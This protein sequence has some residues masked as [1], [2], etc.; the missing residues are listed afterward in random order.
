MWEARETEPQNLG[1]NKSVARNLLSCLCGFSLW[2]S[3]D[4]QCEVRIEQIDDKSTESCRIPDWKLMYYSYCIQNHFIPKL[5]NCWE[6][7]MPWPSDVFNPDPVR[8]LFSKSTPQHLHHFH[9]QFRHIFA[10]HS[11]LLAHSSSPLFSHSSLLWTVG[12]LIVY[13]KSEWAADC[14]PALISVI[15]PGKHRAALMYC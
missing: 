8:P 4:S 12:T 7:N 2:W 13:I 1:K 11:N 5:G 14:S 9:L 3:L 15:A 10:T 6:G